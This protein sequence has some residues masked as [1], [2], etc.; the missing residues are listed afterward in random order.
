MKNRF[1]KILAAASCLAWLAGCSTDHG[2]LNRAGVGHVTVHLTDAPGDF[3]AV[4]IVVTNVSVHRVGS[5]S[6]GWEDLTVQVGTFDLLLLQNGVM[7]TLALG[8]VPVGHYDQIRLRL[9][10]GS[11]VVVNGVTFPLTVPSGLT[12]GL[13][14]IGSFDVVEGQDRQLTLDF[15]AAQ[16]IHTTGTGAYILRPT[17]RLIEGPVVTPPADTTGSITG[18]TLPAGA[19][20]KIYAIQGADTL[21]K[22]T[23]R[24]SGDF[25]LA[26]LIAGTY[27]VA[28]DADSTYRDT[29]LAGVVVSAGQVTALGDIQ[30]QTVSG[31]LVGSGHLAVA[32]RRH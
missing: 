19:S 25:S 17:V 26:P 30:L 16:S 8:N 1:V 4:N 10:D 18:R 9:G 24:S 29:T 21:S 23:N 11:N 15:N 5:D 20:A 7:T 28:I 3:D 22:T 13:K 14:L 32:P 31:A 12:S 2:S 6:D 27:S